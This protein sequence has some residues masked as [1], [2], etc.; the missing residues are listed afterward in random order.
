[1]VVNANYAVKPVT[2]LLPEFQDSG[3]CTASLSEEK[4]SLLKQ[5][6]NNSPL[7]QNSMSCNFGTNSHR[8]TCSV[9]TSPFGQKAFFFSFSPPECMVEESEDEFIASSRT[10]HSLICDNKKLLHYTVSTEPQLDASLGYQLNFVSVHNLLIAFPY[11]NEHFSQAFFGVKRW[12]ASTFH[13]QAI[14][15]VNGE[16]LYL[17]QLLHGW[18]CCKNPSLADL[19][20]VLLSLVRKGRNELEP[21][22]R[23]TL[24]KPKK[25]VNMPNPPCVSVQRKDPLNSNHYFYEQKSQV[26]DD[27]NDFGE[28]ESSLSKGI[29]DLNLDEIMDKLN[30]DVSNHD[31]QFKQLSNETVVQQKVILGSKLEAEKKRSIKRVPKMKLKGKVWKI[32]PERCHKQQLQKKRI[33][34]QNVKLKRKVNDLQAENRMLKARLKLAEKD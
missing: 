20:R 28:S 19:V 10:S 31:C 2:S 7:D 27:N 17:S 3:C 24:I 4:S 1:M 32:K 6:N 22:L 11:L 23:Q 25:F 30:I 29:D 5:K 21:A 34:Q 15:E 8:F 14:T 13:Q 33:H 16:K 26:A 9:P 12:F 18:I